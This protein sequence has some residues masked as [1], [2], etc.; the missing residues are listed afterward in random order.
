M[1]KEECKMRYWKRAKNSKN[2][3]CDRSATHFKLEQENVPAQKLSLSLYRPTIAA[4]PVQKDDFLENSNVTLSSN[5]VKSLL[6]AFCATMTVRPVQDVI[7]SVVSVLPAVPTVANR[8]TIQ[9]GLLQRSLLHA[10]R[11]HQ[12]NMT[13]WRRKTN[14]NRS[15]WQR[16]RTEQREDREPSGQQN[17][18][19]EKQKRKTTE[20]KVRAGATTIQ[21]QSVT[22]QNHWKD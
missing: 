11:N 13:L 5:M 14:E 20:S 16:I 2:A 6:L 8:T 1:E 17:M 7:P 9:H 3:N 18:G 21:K 15:I 10:T 4:Q 19:R 22:N 12:P